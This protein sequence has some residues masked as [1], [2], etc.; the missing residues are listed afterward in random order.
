LKSFVN[1]RPIWTDMC[2]NSCYAYTGNYKKLTKCP[3]CKSDQYYYN[4][5][6]KPC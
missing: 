2:S 5:A 1:I 6:R 4:K 3:I